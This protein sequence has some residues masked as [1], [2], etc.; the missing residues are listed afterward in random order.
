MAKGVLGND[1]FQRGAASRAPESTKGGDGG[2]D[3]AAKPGRAEPAKKSAKAKAGG[4]KAA[5][6]AGKKSASAKAG[7]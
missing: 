6:A 5:T 3:A 7:W 2:K 1:P 4:G